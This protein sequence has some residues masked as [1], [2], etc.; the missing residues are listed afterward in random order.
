MGT[1]ISILVKRK[2]RLPKN[3]VDEVPLRYFSPYYRK[4]A[5]VHDWVSVLQYNC[6]YRSLALNK[7]TYRRTFP[8][9]PWCSDLFLIR[10]S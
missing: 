4:P 2:E 10:I 5:P 9:I 6:P 3:N 7:K 1:I 8:Q